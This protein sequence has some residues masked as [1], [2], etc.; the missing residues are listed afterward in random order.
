MIIIVKLQKFIS[1]DSK[2][3]LIGIIGEAK[4]N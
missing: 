1:S 3:N 4:I 2:N